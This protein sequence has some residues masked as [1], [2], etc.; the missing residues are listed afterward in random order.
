MPHRPLLWA[1]LSAAGMAAAPAHV[2]GLGGSSNSCISRSSNSSNNS[3]DCTD[4]GGFPN[5]KQLSSLNIGL[6][7]VVG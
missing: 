3:S 1:G 4:V 2:Q 5:V 7:L 6:V